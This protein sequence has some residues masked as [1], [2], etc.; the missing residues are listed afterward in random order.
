MKGTTE[1]RALYGRALWR[2]F[3]LNC[4]VTDLLIDVRSHWVAKAA[5]FKRRADDEVDLYRWSLRR[6]R[7]KVVEWVLE[8]H[9][10]GWTW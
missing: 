9:S 8:S 3:C 2:S 6:Q 1:Q 5:R 7:G 4:S 10:L